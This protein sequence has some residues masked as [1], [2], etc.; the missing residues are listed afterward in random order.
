MLVVAALGGNA[1]MKR[2]EAPEAAVMQ[3]NITI[4]ARAIAEIARFHDI[5][6]THGN[7][8]QIGLLALQAEAYDA[9]APYPLDVLGAESEG[10]IGYLIDRELQNQL[11]KRPVA[12]LLT[13]VEVDIDD[14]AFRTP[15]KPIGRVYGEE[16]ARRLARERGW[17]IAPDGGGYRRVVPSPQPRRIVE[18]TAIRLLLDAGVIVV[19]TG[20][21]GIPVAISNSG[22]VRGVEAVVDKDLSSALLASALG[23]DALLL[24]TDIDGVYET[25]PGDNARRIVTGSPAALSAMQFAP[26]TMGPKVEAACAF[27]SETTGF[28]AIGH[29]GLA[30]RI[31]AGETG[32]RIDA[33]AGPIVWS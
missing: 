31:L 24:L 6:V 5:V 4:A 30:S 13:Q 15:T 14:P 22:F 3:R 7:G 32:T 11:P 26:G 23:A 21:G 19:C 1:L 10:M 16:T 8:P 28:A 18:T 25:W 12:T 33:N 9:V 17:T 2:G 27:A 20:G 29:V